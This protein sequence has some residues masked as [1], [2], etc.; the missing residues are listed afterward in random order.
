[1]SSYKDHNE[2]FWVGTEE[3]LVQFSSDAFI[4][5]PKKDLE[6][7]WSILE[8]KKGVMWFASYGHGLKKMEG[9]SIVEVIEYQKLFPPSRF[10]YFYMGGAKAQNGDLIFTRGDRLLKYDSQSFSILDTK[11][12]YDSQVSF[13]AFEVLGKKLWL[14]GAKN[15]VRIIHNEKGFQ[16]HF[17][18]K[19][20]V[21]PNSYIIT[22]NQDKN[23]QFWLGSYRGLTRWDMETD[24]V[25]NYTPKLGNLPDKGIVCSYKDDKGNMWFGGLKGLWLYDYFSDTFRAI[26]LSFIFH[27]VYFITG[28][29]KTHLLIGATD[30]LYVFNKEAF[31]ENGQE[32]VKVLN[33]H[34][35]FTAI[36]PGQ[37]VEIITTNPNQTCS[38]EIFNITVDGY[39]PNSCGGIESSFIEVCTIY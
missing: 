22:I 20:G 12:I 24:S 2:R 6:Y 30:G 13:F 36:E 10:Q 26:A 27:T 34:N 33:H 28:I 4:T 5:Y 38:N 31:Y 9:D 25:W 1:M 35:G 3:G 11:I 29:D 17:G 23:R 8:D 18:R 16:R 21:H 15:G 7:T 39:F 32:I 14:S 19:E 37:N